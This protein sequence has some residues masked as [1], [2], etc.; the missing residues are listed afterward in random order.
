MYDYSG[1][2]SVFKKELEEAGVDYDV[3][4]LAGASYAEIKDTVF[5]KTHFYCDRC[6]GLTKKVKGKIGRDS[7]WLCPSCWSLEGGNGL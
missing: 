2:L 1:D 5:C 4:L 6:N 7:N 3:S